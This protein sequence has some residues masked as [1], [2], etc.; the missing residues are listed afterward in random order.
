MPLLERDASGR[1]LLTSRSTCILH[2]KNASSV[3]QCNV[4]G[5]KCWVNAND[6][7]FAL[8]LSY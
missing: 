6:V 5:E 2:F 8:R 1:V 7:A 4:C 3:A